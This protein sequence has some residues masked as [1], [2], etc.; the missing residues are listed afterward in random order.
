[1][2]TGGDLERQIMEPREAIDL[3][4]EEGVDGI[5][6]TFNE[7]TLWSEYIIETAKLARERGIYIM[8]NTNGYILPPAAGELLDHAD[9][10]NIDV[11]GF[12]ERYYGKICGGSLQEVLDTCML[13]RGKG[14]HV[15]LTYLLVPGLN[16]DADEV[17][18]FSGWVAEKLGP[19][20]P[21]FF[22]RFRPS[23]LL[24]DLPE[25]SM[26]VM[27]R[28]VRTARENGLRFVYLGGVAEVGLDTLCPSCGLPVVER[29]S[30]RPSER[31][32]LKGG[33]VSRFCP[34]FEVRVNIDSPRCPRCGTAVPIVLAG[35]S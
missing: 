30:A 17:A 19:D 4:M 8:V 32:Y 35:R 7:P 27:D 20:T 23:H 24:A 16:D 26:E 2:S 9:V 10:V 25:Q 11:K 12:S 1:M 18:R 28:S 15:E 5:A 6:F 21:V 13:A 33:E 29:R 22:F 34:T 3:A 31:L 14:V